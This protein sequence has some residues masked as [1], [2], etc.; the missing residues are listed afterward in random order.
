[1][2]SNKSRATD[3]QDFAHSYARTSLVICRDVPPSGNLPGTS[4]PAQP[5][6]ASLDFLAALYTQATTEQVA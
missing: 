1:M 2:R 5:S 6:W 3:D 4:H